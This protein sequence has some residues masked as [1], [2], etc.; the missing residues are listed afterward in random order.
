MSDAEAKATFEEL[1]ADGAVSPD[2]EPG[3]TEEEDSDQEGVVSPSSRSPPTDPF[4]ETLNMCQW[5]GW[6]EA[7]WTQ[8][9]I[10]GP[11]Y[12]ENYEKIR[13]RRPI[14]RLVHADVIQGKDRI[15]HIGAE[16]NC[17]ID[18]F[19]RENKL[20][21]SKDEEKPQNLR[22]YDDDFFFIVNFLVP[23]TPSYNV[24]CYFRRIEKHDPTAKLQ[25]NPSHHHFSI[26][27]EGMYAKELDKTAVHAFDLLLK[28]YCCGSNNFRNNRLKIIVN[29]VAGGNW[30][31]RKAIGNKP[32]ILGNKIDTTYHFSVARNYFE[33]D[34][35]IGSSKVGSGIFKIVK[36]Y[37]KG[38]TVDMSFLL[39]GQ[40][41]AELPEILIGG[42]RM[43]QIDTDNAA[44]VEGRE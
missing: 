44:K 12:Q 13:A 7:D 3:K 33:C 16:P 23:S 11:H 5:G 28:R 35:D 6:G 22:Y 20:P 26:Q 41:A 14:F 29:H 43:Y 34:V 2:P 19:Y 15:F 10:R 31:V 4:D 17:F 21:E 27:P 24:V 39:E 36:G 8:L 25:S 37:A 42:I 30:L 9:K 32:A 1:K 18:K 40:E 38:L